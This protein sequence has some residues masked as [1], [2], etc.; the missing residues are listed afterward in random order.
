[1]GTLRYLSLNATGV[2]VW[3]ALAVAPSTR[4]DLA[5]TVAARFEVDV[6]VAERDVERFIVALVSENAVIVSS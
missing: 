5:A 3:D 6:D 1:M 2:V 4:R